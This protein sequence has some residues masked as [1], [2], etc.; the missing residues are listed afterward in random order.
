MTNPLPRIFSPLT[1]L[2][3]Y[4][5]PIMVNYSILGVLNRRVVGG[6]ILGGGDY[7]HKVLIFAAVLASPEQV[8]LANTQHEDVLQLFC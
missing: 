3:H 7:Y 8:P 6:V 5:L 1:P 2:K 4:I